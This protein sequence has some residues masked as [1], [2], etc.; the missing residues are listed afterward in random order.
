LNKIVFNTCSQLDHLLLGAKAGAS[1]RRNWV[2][3]L[4]EAGYL[5]ERKNTH[6]RSIEN[7]TTIMNSELDLVVDQDKLMEEF[8]NIMEKRSKNSSKVREYVKDLVGEAFQ[9]T[10]EI[11]EKEYQESKRKE[12]FTPQPMGKKRGRPVKAKGESL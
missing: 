3:Y 6:P 5:V 12:R 1:L 9:A 7:I 11:A 10:W 8:F 2:D 4:K